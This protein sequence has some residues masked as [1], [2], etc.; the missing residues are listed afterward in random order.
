VS[1]PSI[2]ETQE[3]RLGVGDKT[4][5]GGLCGE[6]MARVKSTY[7]LLVILDIKREWG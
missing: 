5:E 2:A 1:R 4:L 3:G 7:S 6:G